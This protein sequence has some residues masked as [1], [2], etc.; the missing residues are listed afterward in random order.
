MLIRRS[1]EQPVRMPA[2]A[3]GNR[4]ATRTRIMSDDLAIL[5][6]ATTTAPARQPCTT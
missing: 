2:A 6:T 4:I 3:G 5:R 1:H